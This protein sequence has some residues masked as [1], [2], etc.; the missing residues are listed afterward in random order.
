MEGFI[1]K[2]LNS[3][4]MQVAFVEENRKNIMKESLIVTI[5]PARIKYIYD[6]VLNEAL[7]KYENE[8]VTPD[9]QEQMKKRVKY[10]SELVTSDENN[11]PDEKNKEYNN[12]VS[13]EIQPNQNVEVCPTQEKSTDAITL[14]EEQQ[15]MLA[16]LEKIEGRVN[17][18]HEL[19]L[20]AVNTEDQFNNDSPEVQN[21][22]YCEEDSDAKIYVIDNR[23]KHL[24]SLFFPLDEGKFFPN[25][26]EFVNEYETDY[27]ETDYEDVD[28]DD[29]DYEETDY[30]ETNYGKSNYEETDYEET[31]HEEYNDDYA[32]SHNNFYNDNYENDQYNEIVHFSTS[33]PATTQPLQDV[34]PSACDTTNQDIALEDEA[35]NSTPAHIDRKPCADIQEK[36]EE[37]NP[38]IQVLNFVLI[39]I[40]IATTFYI[41]YEL[42]WLP[43]FVYPQ[44]SQ[45]IQWSIYW[46]IPR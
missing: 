2:R 17:D 6:S 20:G 42:K 1:G 41:L 4:A 29:V 33:T 25:N 16:R 35:V 28:Y 11:I 22:L 32:S 24:D 3:H 43:S 21:S 18:L 7:S 36:Q 14:E 39:V 5:D 44:E 23:S 9:Y 13:N 12:A 31:N 26:Y 34:E 10:F 30:E 19:M 27:E 46:D 40:L 37:L 45:N 38:A 15:E 8:P